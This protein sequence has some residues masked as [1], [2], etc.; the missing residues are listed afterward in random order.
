MNSASIAAVK[1]NHYNNTWFLSLFLH[2]A[3]S[4]SQGGVSGVGMSPSCGSLKPSNV[5]N[6]HALSAR[7]PAQSQG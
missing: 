5:A 3:E 2:L 7:R 6:T 1:I 4:A